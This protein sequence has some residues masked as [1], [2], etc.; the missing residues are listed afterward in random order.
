RTLELPSIDEVIIPESPGKFCLFK[1][2]IKQQ[3]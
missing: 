1:V 2:A 3:A